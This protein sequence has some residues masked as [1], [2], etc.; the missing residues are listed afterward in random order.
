M[1]QGAISIPGKRYRLWRIWDEKRPLL[2][3]IL[4][5]PSLGNA[6]DNDPTI[7]RLIYFSRTFGYGGVY[8]GNLYSCISPNPN[9]LK[10]TDKMAE[11]ENINHIK[12]M[13]HMCQ[14]VVYAWGNQGDYPKWL[15]ALEDRP[16]CFGFT[17]KGNPKHPL[18]LPNS[19]SLIN[20]RPK[21]G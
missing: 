19:S 8:V 7:R 3:F 15:N 5:N 11:Q 14:D 2:L 1:Q 12:G 20:F 4:L 9:D 6:T 17:K 21:K 18:Y 16:L 13:M 10:A